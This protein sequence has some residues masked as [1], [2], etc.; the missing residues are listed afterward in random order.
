[1][2]RAVIDVNVIVSAV[3]A[4]LGASRRILLAWAAGAFSPI[5]SDGIVRE[6]GEKLQLSRI[7]R[8]YNIMDAD[9]RW[10]FGLLS[11]QA[12]SIP[13]ADADVLSVTGDPEDDY[14]LATCRLSGADY[15]VTGDRELLDLRSHAATVI[16]SPRQFAGLLEAQSQGR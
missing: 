1:M 16:T 5:I 8:R 7:T 2:I 13:V 12:E 9:R 4:P 11:T 3:I 15:L 14:V 10:V 6:V